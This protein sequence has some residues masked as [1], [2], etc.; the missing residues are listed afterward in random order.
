MKKIFLGLVITIAIL[1]CSKSEDKTVE[2]A[3]IWSFE[4]SWTQEVWYTEGNKPDVGMATPIW[5]ECEW[6][7]LNEEDRYFEYK[8]DNVSTIYTVELGNYQ[9]TGIGWRWEEL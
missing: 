8:H 3:W 2:L 1:S 4:G 7:K 6:I 5:H 9:Q